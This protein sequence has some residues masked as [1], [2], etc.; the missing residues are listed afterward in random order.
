[1]AAD[2]LAVLA[3]KPDIDK[4]LTED[5]SSIHNRYKDLRWTQDVCKRIASFI[6]SGKSVR[7]SLVV[8]TSLLFQKRVPAGAWDVACAMEF[9]H[10]GLLIHDDIMDRDTI[11]RGLPTMHSQ[12]EQYAAV[13]K[14]R[15]VAHFGLSQGINI[16]D[17]CYF[18]GYALLAKGG[19]EAVQFASDELSKVVLAQMQDVGS[20]HLP[21]P[22]TK[23]GVLHLYRYKTARYTFS[24]PM[25]L[26]AMLAGCDIRTQ[27]SLDRLGE[28]LGLLFQIRDDEFDSMGDPN[29]TGKSTGIDAAN[30]K[31]TLATLMTAGELEKFRRQLRIDALSLI[32][33]L[34]I[35]DTHT[36][37]LM[38]LLRFCEERNR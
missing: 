16:A 10:A 29:V 22:Y 11:R 31:Q 26:G 17:F 28:C 13:Q 7:G 9:L 6:V 18:R 5:I 32:R 19:W 30:N 1:M 35:S 12:Y 25:R 21:D 14:G 38:A 2:T 3:Y 33:S 4:R 23:E 27:E 34:P 8:Y 24:L 37:E 20:G 36:R 15:D